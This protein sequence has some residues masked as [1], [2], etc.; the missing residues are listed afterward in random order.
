MGIKTALLREKLNRTHI[1]D[2]CRVLVS[3]VFIFSGFVK[4]IDPWGTALKLEDYFGAFSVE[5][6]SSASIVLS[7]LLCATELALGLGLLFKVRLK[8]F[9]LV[10]LLFMGGFT[11]LTLYFA[12]FNP[13]DD[14]G[15]FGDI[16]KLTNWQTF[17]KNLV[18]LP[19]SFIVWW[20]TKDKKY[21]SF[22]PKE[23]W[24]T[25]ILVILTSGFTLYNQLFLPIIDTTVFKEGVNIADGISGDN[26]EFSTTLVYRNKLTNQEREFQLSDTT[27]YDDTTWEYVDTRV[28]GISDSDIEVT[29]R[30]FNVFD[31]QDDITEQI[32]YD[33][34]T[35]H[36]ISVLDLTKLTPKSSKR[37]AKFVQQA[38]SKGENVICITSSYLDEEPYFIDFGDNYIRCYNMDITTQQVL[39]RAPLGIVTIKDGTILK[40]ITLLGLKLE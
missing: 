39:M 15:C 14:C 2:I 7:I 21:F 26:E 4:S 35:T 17:F 8:L 23:I 27:W 40:K 36:I 11:L 1:N 5:W 28:E 25:L 20:C 18:I 13:I 32:L 10:A 9:S 33:E 38:I 24:L 34:G 19:M 30:D 6:L 29:L 3:A 16:I 37:L 12:I 22:T 31:A